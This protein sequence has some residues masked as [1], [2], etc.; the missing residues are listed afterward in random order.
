MKAMHLIDSHTHLQFAAYD[1][2]RDAVLARMKEK[3]TACINVGTQR[4]TSHAAVELARREAMCF[5]AVGL[6]PTHTE[7][8]YHDPKELGAEGA[9]AKGFTSRGEVF[10]AD[11]Y[12][13]LARDS[14]TVAIGECGLDY[15]R[16]DSDQEK[17]RQSKKIQKDAFEKH[18]ILGKKVGKPL[19]IHCR[20]SKGTDDAYNEL[21]E[22]I[23]PHVDSLSGFIMHFFVGSLEVTK[24]FASRGAYFTFGGAV[25]FARN[26]DDV[27]RYLPG[28]RL[29]CET[30]APYVT[31]EPHRGKRNEPTYVEY[32][33][34][35]LAEIRKTSFE[36]LVD[37]ICKNAEQIFRLEKPPTM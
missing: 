26:Y 18:I 28:D 4:D 8:S 31:P 21:F 34:R 15:F 1:T 13:L 35:K 29:L 12:E 22:I 27:I 37:T 23:L 36:T 17:S 3:N 7:K 32:V 20:P 9:D 24:K 2:D 14:R 19:M 11:Y 16:F 30:D 25:T 6:H 10:D 33:Y 5:A